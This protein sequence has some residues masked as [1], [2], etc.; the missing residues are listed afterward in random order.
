M[1]TQRQNLDNKALEKLDAI[2]MPSISGNTMPRGLTKGHKKTRRRAGFQGA[3]GRLA[4]QQCQYAL[5]LLVGLSQHR[6][7]SL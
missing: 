3:K 6:S 5:R 2:Y 1:R 7:G 4:F